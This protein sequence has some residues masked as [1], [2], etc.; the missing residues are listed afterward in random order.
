MYLSK[1]TPNCLYSTACSFNI[2]T[3]GKNNFTAL[4]KQGRRL[5]ASQLSSYDKIHRT[6]I[7]LNDIMPWQS[8]QG[9]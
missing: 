1:V 6:L 8:D 2:F 7:N 3:V 5:R 9:G 4:G